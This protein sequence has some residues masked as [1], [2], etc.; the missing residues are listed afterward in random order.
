[1]GVSIV[2]AQ[3]RLPKVLE[4][5]EQPDFIAEHYRELAA[6]AFRKHTVP[7]SKQAWVEQS[8]LLRKQVEEHAGLRRFADLALELRETGSS[9]GLGYEVKNIRFQT[10]PGIYATANLYF[11]DGKGPFPAVLVTHGHWPDAR[12]A[13]I[14]QSVAQ[15]LVK[16]GYVALTIDAWGAGERCTGTEQEYHG[17]NLGAS[18]FNIGTTLLGMQ[19]TDNIRAVDLL[20]SLKEVDATRIGATGASGGGNQTMWLA[21]MDQRIK[22]AIPVVSVGTFQSYI[23]NSNCVCELLPNGLVFTEEAAVLGLIAPRALNIFSA[24][25]DTNPSF[26]PRE[27]L[28]SFKNAQLIFEV[29]GAKDQITYRRF[30]TGHGYWPEMRDAMLGWFDLQLKGIGN[31]QDRSG[32]R[33]APVP[34]LQLATY[35]NKEREAEVA[36]TATFCKSEGIMLQGALKGRDGNASGRM[37]DSLKNIIG[38][39]EARTIARVDRLG[40]ED[41]WNRMVLYTSSGQA[42]PFLWY[43]ATGI[44]QAYRL[45]IHTGGKDSIPRLD[46][47]QAKKKGENIILLDLWGTGEQASPV[48]TKIDGQLPPFHTLS[49]SALWLGRTVIGEWEADLEGLNNWIQEQKPAH[50]AIQSYK[51]TA[52]AALAFSAWNNV[53]ELILYDCPY[54]YLFDQRDGIDFYTMAVHVPNIL[55]WGDVI[56]LLALGD[57]HIEM[58]NARSMSGKP[59]D[60]H[61]MKEFEKSYHA[62]RKQLGSK[63]EVIFKTKNF[64]L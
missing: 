14:F 13:E 11:P 50:L 8:A 2:K 20:C 55:A 34:A 6:K 17:A 9:K 15:T 45:F 63:S 5:E 39:R 23:F 59:L 42:I 64:K 35:P 51:E 24:N 54:S 53:D 7:A 21:A 38:E 3:D 52:I 41:G 31:G 40:K 58:V 33:V 1:M 46:I 28:R 25:Q 60:K 32:P 29:M 30:E 18:L 56:T 47:E 48:A 57:T 10:R 26:V 16:S 61:H 36:T 4:S 27:M 49:R 22:A 62:V 19:L 44:H 43:P 12:R 37:A